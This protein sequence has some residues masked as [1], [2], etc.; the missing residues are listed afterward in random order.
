MRRRLGVTQEALDEQTAPAAMEPPCPT[1]SNADI[2][3]VGGVWHSSLLYDFR[4]ILPTVCYVALKE[5]LVCFEMIVCI[6]YT[7]ISKRWFLYLKTTTTKKGIEE[8]CVGKG[9]L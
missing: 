2:K 1:V 4:I 6:S 5:F 8:R 9:K 3:T 7:K